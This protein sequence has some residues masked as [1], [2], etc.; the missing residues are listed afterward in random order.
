MI[1]VEISHIEKLEKLFET[2]PK[3]AKLILGHSINRAAIAARTRASVEARKIYVVKS[4]DIKSKIKIRKATHN[5]LSAQIRVAGPVTPLMKFD[6]TPTTPQTTEVRARV[7]KGGKKPI[8][9]G[10]VTRMSS[11]HTNV[12]TR[13]GKNRFPI[14]GLYGPSIAQMFSSDKVVKSIEERSGQVLNDRLVH[15][16]DRLLRG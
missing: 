8:Q 11:G 3:E 10:F 15:E 4:S 1:Q 6:V 13:V 12:F 7:K 9:N 14:K 16:F 2:T 5:L